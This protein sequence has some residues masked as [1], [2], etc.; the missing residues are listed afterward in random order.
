MT[1]N[2]P[3]PLYSNTPDNTHC[4]QAALRMVLKY[5]QPEREFTWEELDK[6]SGKK[7]GMWTWPAAAELWIR[8]QGY[9]II[10]LGIF[11]NEEFSKRPQAYLLEFFGEK[12]G[13]EQIEH[14]DIKK[15]AELAK[16]LYEAGIEKK[17]IPTLT[18]IRELLKKGYLIICLVNSR[19]LRNRKG[20]AGHSVVIRGIN[21]KAI[22]INN[23]GLPAQENEKVALGK[24]EKAWAYPDE[25]DKGLT[26][27][28]FVDLGTC[29][30]RYIS[31]C[32]P[33]DWEHA[34]RVVGWIKD[35]GKKRKDLNLL[36]MAGYLHDIGWKGLITGKKKISRK[37]LLKWQPAADRQTEKLTRRALTRFS[38]TEQEIEKILR[39]IRATET[40][41]A[42]KRDEMILVDADN[43]SKTAPEHIKEKYEKNDW[44]AVC[45]LFEKNFPQRI[46]TARGKKLFPK[47]LAELRRAIKAELA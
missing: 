14:A 2:Y 31:D 5:F 45:D 16:Q 10:D 22:F 43:L 26:A 12:A 40:Y 8:D 4:F 17:E 30:K 19:V 47:K 36:I 32:R 13:R 33:G 6:I 15:E 23:P 41:R 37:E 25:K 3:V 28:K 9:K 42:I 35:L 20:Y 44:L 29:F 38:L 21:E 7:K 18:T 34:K 27:F 1:I 46:K 39:L 24:F 11:D